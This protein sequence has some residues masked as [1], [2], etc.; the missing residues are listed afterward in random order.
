MIIAI[1]GNYGVGKDTFADFLIEA[2]KEEYDEPTEKIKSYTTR[3]KRYEEED[4]HTFITK[5]EWEKIPESKILAQ[6]KINNEYYGT[7]IN[8]FIYTFNIYVVDKKGVS[9]LIKAK[10]NKKIKDSL[11]IVKITRPESLI[12]IDNKRRNRN[13]AYYDLSDQELEKMTMYKVDNTG[14]LEELQKTAIFLTKI[15]P[16]FKLIE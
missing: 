9:D 14:S 1:Y 16:Y 3:K 10:Q 4:T 11:F 2:L 8:Q 5:K 13:I 15:L 6:T 12:Q 7:T